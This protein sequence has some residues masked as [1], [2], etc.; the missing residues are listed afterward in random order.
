MRAWVLILT[1][2]EDAHADAVEKHLVDAGVGVWRSDTATADLI[3]HLGGT[4]SP[5]GTLAGCDL[6]RVRCVWHRRP[7]EPAAADAFAVA[8][9][10][11]ALGGVLAGLPHLNHPADMATA[12]LKPYQLTAASR[13]GLRVPETVVATDPAAGEA[14]AHRYHGQVVVKPLSRG[15]TGPVTHADRAGWSRPVH[16]TQRRVDK[17]YDVR[18]TVVDRRLFAVAIESPHL[19]W[20]TDPDECRYRTVPVPAEVGRGVRRLLAHLR[21]RYAALDF[22]VDAAGDWWFLEVNPNGQWL[23]LEQATALPISAAVAT[24]LATP[25]PRRAWTYPTTGAGS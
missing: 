16:L 2:P 8:E 20:R 7:S 1:H 23:W 3:A 25:Q 17:A 24:A 5:R 4:P 22:A 11:A 10:R 9:L 19:D 12:A 14:L 13:A 6:T 18:L 21:L 15:A